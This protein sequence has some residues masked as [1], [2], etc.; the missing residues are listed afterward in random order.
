M[1]EGIR[2][3]R[4]DLGD[5]DDEIGDW[6]AGHLADLCDEL[7]RAESVRASRS[8]LQLIASLGQ[9]GV[10]GPLVHG[11]AHPLAVVRAACARAL[12]GCAEAHGALHGALGDPDAESGSR[13]SRR[14][15]LTRTPISRRC[16]RTRTR[17]C[18]RPPPRV[19]RRPRSSSCG[20]SK[21]RIASRGSP[22]SR[23][24]ARRTLRGSRRSSAT[25]IRCFARPRSSGSPRWPPT[26]C[27]PTRSR[28]RSTP[29]IRGCAAPRCA[30]PRGR[31]SASPASAWR[32]RCAIRSR[33]CAAGP[34]KRSLPLATPGPWPRCP[35]S[36]IRDEATAGAALE[37][38]AGGVHPRRRHFLSAELRRRA[39]LAWQAL[40]GI[41]LLPDDGAP[42]ARFLRAATTDTLLRQHRI[43]F[44]ALELLE[45]PRV[46]RR[47]ER[48]LRFGNPRSRGDALEVLSNLGDRAA[49]RLL[50]LFHEPGPIE[51]R[52]A[53][54]GA[55]VSLPASREAFLA[56][57]RRSED[58]WMR[59]ALAAGDRPWAKLRTPKRRS[60]SDS[61]PSSASRCSR[62]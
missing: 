18:A 26:A 20:C 44:R 5:L 50:V 36:A 31:A 37:A 35:T 56:D 48:A 12:A 10:A 52:V 6:E 32:E 61:S 14:C 8:L 24:R 51:E 62:T 39:G 55:A 23:W 3:G 4:L 22:R 21:V 13:R 54:L 34:R 30:R 40:A 9:R 59:M 1:I 7:L 53:A 38:V 49:A 46:V 11:L 41:G 43:A 17:A 58:R 19:R 33:R 28:A 15:P 16:W 29:T 60:W 27:P 47:V 25:T 42:G 57:A 2:T 45:S